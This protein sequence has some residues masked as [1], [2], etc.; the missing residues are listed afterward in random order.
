MRC[1]FMAD[2]H[3]ASVEMLDPAKGDEGC[4]R[5]AQTLFEGRAQKFKADGFEI[6]DEARLVFRYPAGLKTPRQSSRG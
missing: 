6:W 3:I 1:F 4:I 5:Q 2:G